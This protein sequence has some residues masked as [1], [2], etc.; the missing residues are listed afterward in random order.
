MTLVRSDQLVLGPAERREAVLEAVRSAQRDLIL[1]IFRCDDF[2]IIDEIAAAVGRNVAVRVLMTRQARGWE[3][4]LK[5]LVA[6]LMSAGAQVYRYEGPY[7]KYHAKYLV[8]DD[9]TALVAT[10]NLT[11]KCFTD[12]CDFLFVT[13]QPDVIRGLTALFNADC[14]LPRGPLPRIT[15]RLIIGPEQTRDRLTSFLESAR[16]S[17][18]VVDDRVTDPQ[19]LD[20][21]ESKSRAGVKVRI[22]GRGDLAGMACHGRMITMD[23]RRAIIGSVALSKSSLDSRREVAVVID[24]PDCVKT[25]SRLF[26][27][28]A[29]HARQPVSEE[30]IGVIDDDDDDDENDDE[31]D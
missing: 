28:C 30:S 4:R 23:N 11:V 12:T 13:P 26:D 25:L 1:S 17:I 5:G 14:R 10:F 20:L 8:A 19:I 16:E 3:K 27:H 15:D 24:E 21:L 7:F 29:A 9:A 2:R 22:L 31:S 18:S 6:L